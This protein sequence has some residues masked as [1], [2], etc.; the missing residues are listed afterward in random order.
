M[1]ALMLTGDVRLLE[2]TRQTL[3]KSAVRRPIGTNIAPCWAN[4]RLR[5]AVNF[6]QE[7]EGMANS[8]LC[9]NLI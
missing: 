1:P 3:C 5:E 8:R 4:R 2:R 7:I 6:W 9:G